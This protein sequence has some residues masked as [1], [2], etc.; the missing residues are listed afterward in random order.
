M[1]AAVGGPE[2]QVCSQGSPCRVLDSLQGGGGGDCS[3]NLGPW[4]VLP[5]GYGQCRFYFS[6][7]S[8]R[9]LNPPSVPGEPLSQETPPG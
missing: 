4:G 7:A 1:D 9:M 3:G 2:L 8:I 5:S 6:L